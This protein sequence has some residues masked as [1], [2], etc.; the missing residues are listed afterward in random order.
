MKLAAYLKLN[1]ESQLAFSERCEGV[2]RSTI[3]RLAT[4]VD[5]P[6]PS[7]RTVRS[8]MDATDDAV[9]YEDFVEQDA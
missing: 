5:Y 4:G 8:I 7:V 6:S 2:S 9:R 3:H 1:D